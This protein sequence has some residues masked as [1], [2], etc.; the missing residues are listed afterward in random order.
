[1][2]RMGSSFY[3]GVR[4]TL[5]PGI[6]I[7]GPNSYFFIFRTNLTSLNSIMNIFDKYVYIFFL[8]VKLNSL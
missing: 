3:N 2:G 5:R 6:V 7:Y 8:L 4:V 1:M